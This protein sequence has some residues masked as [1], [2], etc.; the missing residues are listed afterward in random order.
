MLNKDNPGLKVLSHNALRIVAGLLFAQ[1]GAQKLFGVLERNQAELASLMGLAGIIE[2][3][4]GLLIAVGLFTR[5]V[6]F[7]ACGQM[8]VAYFM[9][10]APQ[11]FWPIL[12][13]GE[14]AAF[15]CFTW[16]F[17]FTHGPGKYSVDGWLACRKAEAE[18]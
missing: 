5:P 17:F 10:H 11:G 13:G 1:H 6:A 8:A 7:L 2:F 14:L 4:G 15:Y 16:L 9:A 18:G 12:N 3:F